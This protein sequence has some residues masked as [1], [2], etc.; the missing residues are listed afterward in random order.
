MPQCSVT[1]C[2]NHTTRNRKADISFHRFPKDKVRANDWLVRIGREG[3]E[4]SVQARICSIHFSEDCFDRNSERGILKKDAA[5][6][7]SQTLQPRVF[8][9]YKFID[10]IILNKVT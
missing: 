1:G 8:F 6:K 10:K 2:R 7:S 3:F 9:Y 4:P 5:P